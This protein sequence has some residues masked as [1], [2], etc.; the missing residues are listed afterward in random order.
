MASLLADANRIS[1]FGSAEHSLLAAE[2]LDAA[3]ISDP[4]EAFVDA[5]RVEYQGFL[6]CVPGMGI[7]STL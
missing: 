1:V 4:P 7:V 5:F 6:Q 3:N 2:L